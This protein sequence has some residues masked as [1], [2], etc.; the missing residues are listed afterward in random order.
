[1]KHILIFV[2]FIFSLPYINLNAAETGKKSNSDYDVFALTKKNTIQ[3]DKASLE[4]QKK[5][6]DRNIFSPEQKKY[7]VYLPKYGITVETALTDSRGLMFQTEIEKLE[8]LKDL[9]YSYGHMGESKK[10]FTN[11]FLNQA[12][13]GF[14]RGLL[15]PFEPKGSYLLTQKIGLEK[16]NLDTGEYDCFYIMVRIFIIFLLISGFHDFCL[17]IYPILKFLLSKPWILFKKLL[18]KID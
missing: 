8:N 9:Y 6:N 4:K 5:I 12:C 11:S 2:I 13:R 18:E 10:D 1:M 15:T 3:L 14:I 7:S 16:N 17:F